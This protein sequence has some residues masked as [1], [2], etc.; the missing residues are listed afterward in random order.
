MSDML[1][2]LDQVDWR[3]LTH[4]YGAAKDVPKLLRLLMDPREDVREEALFELS[5]SINHQG[6]IYEATTFAVP[7]LVEMACHPAVP[8]RQNVLSLISGAA[9]GWT[10]ALRDAPD[11]PAATP[12]AFRCSAERIA[13]ERPDREAAH[14]AVEREFAA[15]EA[16]LTDSAPTVRVA[17]AFVIANLFEHGESAACLLRMI[18]SERDDWCRAAAI[19]AL[20]EL[21]H[22]SSPDHVTPIANRCFFEVFRDGDSGPDSRL[23]AG[24]ALLF[25][26]DAAHQEETLALAR[27]RLA[28]DLKLFW[29]LPSMRHSSNLFSLV[30]KSLHAWPEARVAWIL[31]G[32][33]SP[34]S[35]IV[36]AAVSQSGTLCREVR[37]GPSRM[38]S[39]L[40]KLADSPD[41]E[42]HSA[43]V[44]G[45]AELGSTGAEVL[46]ELADHPLESVRTEAAE[47]LARMRVRETERM[48][49]FDETLPDVMESVSSLIAAIERH[50]GSRHWNDVEE[51]C[52][53]VR[54][55][56][57][58][59]PAAEEG[60]EAIRRQI[61]HAHTTIATNVL[62]ASQLRITA[63]RAL[64]TITR[65]AETVVPL[66]I[67]AAEPDRHG[68]LAIEQ[69]REIGP[70]AS[71]ALP[72]LRRIVES[73]RRLTPDGDY[74]GCCPDDE[75]FQSA[76]QTAID[77]IDANPSGRSADC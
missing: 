19:L 2:Q 56:G 59:G 54:E 12:L 44:D 41:P 49:R 58:H 14:R 8:D 6:S 36:S 34:Q 24:L 74:C 30:T 71:A 9:D 50:E 38:A 1:E 51:V 28:P 66:A 21:A 68:L 22:G 76:A 52:R 46:W 65:D 75:A 40:R 69:L 63:I 37:W 64:W 73:E 33:A 32:L 10:A 57:F 7:F 26:G 29:R 20:E 61:R 43:A 48:I 18:E 5:N 31:E 13:A 67:Q 16:L 55:L 27:P 17:A 23:S 70:A 35:K 42:K 47:R 53:A 3:H 77:A 25:R 39:A 62:A 4:A 11:D 72:V 15:I 60:T 45:L